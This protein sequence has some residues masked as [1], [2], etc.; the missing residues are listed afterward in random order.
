M[1]NAALKPP[2][3]TRSE[4]IITMIL[5]VLRLDVICEKYKKTRLNWIFICTALCPRTISIA[6]IPKSLSLSLSRSQSVG[7]HARDRSFRLHLIELI[8]QFHD[9]VDFWAFTHFIA[10]ILARSVSRSMTSNISYFIRQISF[11]LSSFPIVGWIYL[12]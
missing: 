5:I 6:F 10:L 11:F 3:F 12:R 1:D 9:F 2:E 7:T 4:H 8:T